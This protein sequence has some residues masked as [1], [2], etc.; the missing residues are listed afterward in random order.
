MTR[1]ISSSR[2]MTVELAATGQLGEVFG[3]FFEGL[4][5]CFRILIG[6]ALRAAY[7][8][9]ALEDG[10]VRRSER[11]E[12][13][14]C[15]VIFLLREGEQEVLGR[16]VLVLE[17]VGFLECL[18]EDLLH[19]IGHAGLRAGAGN[20][21]EFAQGLGCF[22]DELVGGYADFLQDRDDDAVLVFKQGGEQV[23]RQQ[24]RVAVLGRERARALNRF[25]RFHCEFIPTDC[26]I[27]SQLS[28]F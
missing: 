24:L 22:C 14:L 19:G 16:D 23:Q 9:Q 5:L 7:G 1:R 11:G 4:E 3:V 13:Q 2:P 12:Q 21:G 20:L 8:A 26:H 27:W 17:I 10:V 25:L 15:A 28:I 18:V 6:H